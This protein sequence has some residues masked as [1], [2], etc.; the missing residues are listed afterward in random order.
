MLEIAD[1]QHASMGHDRCQCSTTA[2]SIP[3]F[4]PR[5]H[6]RLAV[7]PIPHSRSRSAAGIADWDFEKDNAYDEV[8]TR[9]GRNLLL[10]QKAEQLMKC[11]LTLGH[12]DPAEGFEQ[13]GALWQKATLQQLTNQLTDR[14]NTDGDHQRRVS[15]DLLAREQHRFMDDLLPSLMPGTLARFRSLAAEL[16]DQRERILPEIMR[17]REDTMVLQGQLL[18]LLT[19]PQAVSG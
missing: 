10:F 8:L 9:I 19:F 3:A 17:L 7:P 12:A 6:F 5:P 16:D 15:I 14:T 1:Y 13:P 2:E 18:E 11:L 4:E